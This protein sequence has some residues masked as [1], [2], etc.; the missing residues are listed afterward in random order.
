MYVYIIIDIQY[1]TRVYNQANMSDNKIEFKKQAIEEINKHKIFTF[2]ANWCKDCKYLN[3][4]FTE[5]QVPHGKL[6]IGDLD[7]EIQNEWRDAFEELTGGIRNLPSIFVN[8]KYYCTESK[9]HEWEDAG[10]LAQELKKLEE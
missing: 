6:D 9:I 5:Y 1:N 10:V 3:K 8:G 2:E 7:K 4:I